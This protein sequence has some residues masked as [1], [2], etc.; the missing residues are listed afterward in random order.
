VFGPQRARNR[1]VFAKEKVLN[2]IEVPRHRE[3]AQKMSNYAIERFV[4][5]IGDENAF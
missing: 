5:M 4:P 2:A 3:T 1:L